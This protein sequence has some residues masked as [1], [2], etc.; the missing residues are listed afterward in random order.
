M[1]EPTVDHDPS[2]ANEQVVR[3]FIAA[4]SSLDADRLVA[5]FSEDGVYHNMML[6]PVSGH[7]ALREFIGGFVSGWDETRW[8][9]LH[10]L[11]RGDLVMAERVDHTR[12]GQ[13][14]VALPCVGVFEMRDRRIRAWRDYFD[15]DTYRKAFEP[16]A[17]ASGD[18]Q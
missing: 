16:T 8:E 7:A 11:A 13:R 9:I 12:I 10:V 2:A 18:A 15:L 3:Q 14:R 6:P 1:S 17:G 5:F 4:W